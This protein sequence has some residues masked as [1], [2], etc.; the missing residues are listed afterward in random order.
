M[1][2][3]YLHTFLMRALRIIFKRTRITAA[4]IVIVLHAHTSSSSQLA[5][6]VFIRITIEAFDEFPS[7]ALIANDTMQCSNSRV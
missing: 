7:R 3:S 6:A 1:H 5:E 2:D 4:L